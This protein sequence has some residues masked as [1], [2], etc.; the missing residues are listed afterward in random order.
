MDTSNL[1][2]VKLTLSMPVGENAYD[3]SID[4]IVATPEPASGIALLA[5]ALG[6]FVA[7]RKRKSSGRVKQS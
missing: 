5:G 7:W 6:A 2:Y 4:S 1:D 3:A